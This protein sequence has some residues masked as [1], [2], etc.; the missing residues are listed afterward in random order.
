MARFTAL[1]PTQTSGK[2][3]EILGQIEKLLGVTP[4]LFRVAAQSPSCLEGLFALTGATSK[5]TLSAQTREAIALTVAES[6]GCDYCLSAHAVLGKGAG[7][8]TRFI[9]QFR[10][11]KVS[12]G[13][14]RTAP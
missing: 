13:E 14:L 9:P 5:G 1:D 8:L 11:L 4:N 6:N 7:C 10:P 3:R 12:R 2:I